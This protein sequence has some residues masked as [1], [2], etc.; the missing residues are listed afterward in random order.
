MELGGREGEL[1]VRPRTPHPAPHVIRGVRCGRLPM[2]GRIGA[3]VLT[4]PG[5][6]GKEKRVVARARP[7]RLVRCDPAWTRC[8]GTRRVPAG[9]PALLL[10]VRSRHVPG[11]SGG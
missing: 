11:D 10:L 8:S 2:P 7:V 9:S 5:T 1:G 4:R 3:R 6:H